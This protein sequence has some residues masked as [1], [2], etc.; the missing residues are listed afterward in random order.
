MF[1]KKLHDLA[2]GEE[3]G[4]KRGGGWVGNSCQ[5]IISGRIEWEH[6]CREIQGERIMNK[7]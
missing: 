4:S 6:A 7:G 3:Y 2:Q 5:I 1:Y